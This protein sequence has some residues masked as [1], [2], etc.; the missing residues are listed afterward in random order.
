M[1]KSPTQRAALNCSCLLAQVVFG[2]VD[3]DIF[4]PKLIVSKEINAV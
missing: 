4:L 2:I 3:V 1:E